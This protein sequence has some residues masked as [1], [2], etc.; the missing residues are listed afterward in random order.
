MF[1]QAFFLMANQDLQ[2]VNKSLSGVIKEM[3]STKVVH[4]DICQLEEQHRPILT[5]LHS[6]TSTPGPV[7]RVYRAQNQSIE[8]V[9]SQRLFSLAL[10]LH[11]HLSHGAKASGY[12]VVDLREE[13]SPRPHG[14]QLLVQQHNV[15]VPVQLH[16]RQ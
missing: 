8:L 12:P 10:Q 16:P 3:S 6:S 2:W 1:V 13:G 11:H 7:R 5:V 4:R 15:V 14:S 9:P